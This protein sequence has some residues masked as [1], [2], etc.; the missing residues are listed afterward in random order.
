MPQISPLETAWIAFTLVVLIALVIATSSRG[1]G[2][3][4]TPHY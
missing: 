3:G 1:P 4:G 2:R